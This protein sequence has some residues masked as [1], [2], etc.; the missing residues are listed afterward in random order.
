MVHIVHDYDY[1]GNRTKRYDAVR[2]ANSELY[3]YDKLNQIKNLKRGELNKEQTEVSVATHSEAWNFDKT[4]NWQQYTR[5]WKVENRP[6][7]AA[8]EL[9]NIVTHDANGNMILMPGLKCK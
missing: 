5:N 3:Q 1:A 6:H 9:Q 2:N 7:S 8:N 4:G